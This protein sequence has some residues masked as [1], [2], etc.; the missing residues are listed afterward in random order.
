MF[1]R[2]GL[3]PNLVHYRGVCALRDETR[4]VTEFAPLSSLDVLLEDE[5][6]SFR[7]LSLAHKLEALRQVCPNPSPSPSP[8]P[9]LE[10]LRQVCEGMAA[11]AIERLVH[12][13]LAL[14]NVLV[15]AYDRTN[16]RATLVKV[17]D[18][19][20]CVA[21]AS[22]NHV[23]DPSAEL[24]VRYMPPEALRQGRFSEVRDLRA[25][26]PTDHSPR[27]SR[28]AQP[29]AG[30]HHLSVTPLRHVTPLYCPPSRARKP[31]LVHCR[32]ALRYPILLYA[33]R[34]PTCG[35]SV[36]SRGSY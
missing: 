21:I 34:C 29:T 6:A 20:L 31:L 11:L 3:H 35:R 14:R 15:F 10:V 22:A 17:T 1:A 26:A 2:L 32:P 18:F 27:L 28:S 5:A 4:I 23:A 8:S 19:G 7:T 12:R 24:P 25:S 16:P 30:P 9:K 33:F 36:S 13:D